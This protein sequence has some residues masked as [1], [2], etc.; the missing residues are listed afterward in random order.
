MDTGGKLDYSQ[1]TL[2]SQAKNSRAAKLIVCFA[3]VVPQ[4]V[5]IQV[6]LGIR[7]VAL[8]FKFLGNKIY[9]GK[10]HFGEKLHDFKEIFVG[11]VAFIW[12]QIYNEHNP[13]QTGVNF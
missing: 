4:F 10:F 8:A 6:F 13:C 11:D 9:R 5:L 1:Y 7:D 3:Q 12:L 2:Y